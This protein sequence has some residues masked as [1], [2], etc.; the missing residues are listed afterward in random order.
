MSK[1]SFDPPESLVISPSALHLAPGVT[2]TDLQRYHVA[3]VLDLFAA[4][5]T[6]S[7]LDDNFSEDAVHED[8][9]ASAKNREEVGGQLLHLTT[10]CKSARTLS[11]TVKSVRPTTTVHEFEFKLPLPKGGRTFGMNTTLCIFSSAAE[12]KIVRLQDRP[13]DQIPDNALL[14]VLRKMNAVGVPKVV[15]L[16][17]DE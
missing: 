16:P 8:L 9:F 7:K 11:H 10:I 6:R 15:G 2:L 17:D 4:K 12:R 3:L 5:G 1:V 14:S 13:M